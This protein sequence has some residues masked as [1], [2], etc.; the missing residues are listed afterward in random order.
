MALRSGIK[1]IISDLDDTAY[2]QPPNVNDIHLEG[3]VRAALKLGFKGSA[4]D[5]REIVRKEWRERQQDAGRVFAQEHGIDLGAYTR[6]RHR[7]ILPTYLNILKPDPELRDA[8]NALGT[9]TPV[10]VVTH[11]S[12]EWGREL[13]THL[14]LKPAH[15]LG[16]DH[17]EIDFRK[18]NESAEPFLAA[19]EMLGVRPEEIAVLE[20]T[21]SNLRH[22]WLLHMQTILV[23]WDKPVEKLPQHIDR[24]VSTLRDLLPKAA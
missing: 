17:P 3:A 4:G 18:K 15:I 19:A 14:G 1:A 5:A 8:F 7:E 23:T 13:T 2:R 11:A 16:I 21:P 20:D 6:L 9:R 10:V 22:P 24:Q 12:Q